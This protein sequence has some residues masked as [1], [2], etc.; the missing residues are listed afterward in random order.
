MEI[1][2][3]ENHG[4]KRGD[5]NLKAGSKNPIGMLEAYRPGGDRQINDGYSKV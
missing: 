1:V 2:Q 4:G 3:N 5:E